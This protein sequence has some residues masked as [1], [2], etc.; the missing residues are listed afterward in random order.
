[1]YRK[2]ARGMLL[3]DMLIFAQS[4]T[5]EKYE[6]DITPRLTGRGNMN[7]STGSTKENAVS[8]FVGGRGRG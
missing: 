4:Y 8:F 7:V 5:K 6:R 1:M 2:N 3:H